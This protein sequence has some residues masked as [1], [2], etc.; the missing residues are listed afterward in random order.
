MET[1]QF[2]GSVLSGQRRA[3][4]YASFLF[5]AGWNADR[6]AGVRVTSFLG[7]AKQQDKRRLC[8][9]RGGEGDSI[10]YLIP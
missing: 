5:P 8:V 1:V 9:S 4:P 7:I 6:E 10:S 2:P 3:L